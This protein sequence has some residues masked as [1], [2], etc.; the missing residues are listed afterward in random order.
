MGG[1]SGLLAYLRY[2]PGVLGGLIGLGLIGGA[3][4]L[5]VL[6]PPDPT[7]GGVQ[8]PLDAITV[9]AT[10][11]STASPAPIQTGT[12]E[13]FAPADT[14]EN[15]D[16][17][18]PQFATGA[19]SFAG[20]AEAP[21]FSTDPANNS[22]SFATGDDIVDPVAEDMG[23]E[24]MAA[25]DRSTDP[26]PA[27]EDVDPTTGGLPRVSEVEARSTFV[28]IEGK[29]PLRAAP[30]ADLVQ[31]TSQG[32][33]PIISEDGEKYPWSTYARPFRDTTVRPRV[34]LLMVGLGINAQATVTALQTLPSE[35]SIAFPPYARNIDYW[36]QQSRQVGHE[37]FM[38]VP[39]EPYDFPTN[40]PGPRTLM[41]T[42]SQTDNRERLEWI[43]TR[44]PG[45]VGAINLMG[46]RFTS[47]EQHMADFMTQL[48][49]HGLSFV[50][51]RP[52]EFS[53]S[54][55][56]ARRYVIPFKQADLV[57]DE[58][59][60][61]EAIRS[62]LARLEEIANTN[63][64]ALGVIHAYP[65]TLREVIAWTEEFDE[66]GLVLAPVTAILTQGGTTQASR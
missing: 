43:M 60:G 66:K 53:Y 28:P 61:A 37:V 34:A 49:R 45:Y 32:P 16:D 29:K 15:T 31:S 46:G 42:L 23:A 54:R 65:V 52:A 36:A 38:E 24:D 5:W 35:I 9:E 30:D 40:D 17:V 3:V 27:P 2:I 18:A 6:V 22:P 62:R 39:M 56:L 41:T 51:Q 48:R 11:D 12:A 63:R 25:A 4:A 58:V 50:E 20:G 1:A 21:S 7:F 8:S 33:L 26:A 44:F 57:I 14:P 55:D 47:S 59:P 13:Q 10:E 64:T 19:P